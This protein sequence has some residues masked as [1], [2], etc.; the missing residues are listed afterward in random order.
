MNVGESLG[1][2][3]QVLILGLGI[4]L[5][6]LILLIL[7]VE[8]MH[9]LLSGDRNKETATTKKSIDT[10]DSASSNDDNDDNSQIADDEL[11]AVISAAIASML[12]DYEQPFKIKSIKHIPASTPKWNQIGRR[13]QLLNRR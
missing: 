13:E 11:V 3:L 5:V 4:T 6:A 12:D 8:I 9:K 10:V 7:V 1:E 2:G